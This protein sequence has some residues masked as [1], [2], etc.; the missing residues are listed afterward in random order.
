MERE[1]EKILNKHLNKSSQMIFLA[2]PRQVGKT[3]IAKHILETENGIYLNWD[4]LKDRELILKG[5]EKIM[6]K[7]DA[8]QLG[9]LPPITVLDE[10]HKFKDWKNY[11]K[12]FYDQFGKSTRIIVTGSSRLDI[13]TRGGDSL[14]GRY[15]PY[16]VHP[17]TI[18]EL[19]QQTKLENLISSPKEIS[20]KNWDALWNFGGFPDP[21]I[22]ADKNFFNQWQNTR[23]VYA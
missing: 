14:M 11:L 17:I 3:T 13:F 2:G 12:G 19:S 8:P 9:K 4:I 21:F 1:Y 5:P 10:I 22:Q 20:T 16:T 15:F 23:R 18:R 7:H 6:E